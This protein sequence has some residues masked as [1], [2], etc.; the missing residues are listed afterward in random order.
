MTIGTNPTA[1]GAIIP[2]G[3]QGNTAALAAVGKE[4]HE[5]RKQDGHHYDTQYGQNDAQRGLFRDKVPNYDIRSVF[6]AAG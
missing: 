6:L 2:F 4:R 3:S 1:A 5:R